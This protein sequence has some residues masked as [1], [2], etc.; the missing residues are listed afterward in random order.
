M[1]EETHLWGDHH[2][3]ISKLWSNLR[4]N[5]FPKNAE[6]APLQCLTPAHICHVILAMT[7]WGDPEMNIAWIRSLGTTGATFRELCHGGD[8]KVIS[9]SVP[10]SKVSNFVEAAQKKSAVKKHPVCLSFSVSWSLSFSAFWS[11]FWS[12]KLGMVVSRP[13][14]LGYAFGLLFLLLDNVRKKNKLTFWTRMGWAGL[15]LPEFGVDDAHTMGWR[16]YLSF[17]ASRYEAK[18]IKITPK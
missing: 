17:F 2:W 12:C 11:I 9:S 3:G 7:G 10:H 5:A 14:R 13:S 6:E 4:S 16:M 1:L 8:R 15:E 18:L